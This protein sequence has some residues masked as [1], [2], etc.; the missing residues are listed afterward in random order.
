[1]CSLALVVFLVVAQQV[2]NCVIQR[3]MYVIV[4]FFAKTVISCQLMSV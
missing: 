3:T 4:L 2:I 1:M